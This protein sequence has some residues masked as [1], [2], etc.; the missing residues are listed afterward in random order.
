L[1]RYRVAIP[2]HPGLLVIA[3]NVEEARCYA[4]GF[5]RKEVKALRTLDALAMAEYLESSVYKNYQC[6]LSVTE[7]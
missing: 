6:Y 7:E 2:G 1:K 5:M 4:R 3:R